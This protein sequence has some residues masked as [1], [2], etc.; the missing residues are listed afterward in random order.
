MLDKSSEG[1]EQEQQLH[2]NTLGKGGNYQTEG[3]INQIKGQ[4]WHRNDPKLIS[5]KNE[6]VVSSSLGSQKDSWKDEV[7][8]LKG[9]DLFV[10]CLP[11]ISLTLEGFQWAP[12]KA[13]RNSPSPLTSDLASRVWLFLFLCTPLTYSEKLA[14]E[15]G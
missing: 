12:T 1:R 14:T 6:Q 2:K 3:R 9:L 15:I 5:T 11:W 8:Q 10:L 7:I 13:R 4:R